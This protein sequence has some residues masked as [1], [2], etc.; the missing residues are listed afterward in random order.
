MK[1]VLKPLK[2]EQFEVEADPDKT[3]E[4]LKKLVAEARSE[5]PAD[6][7]KLIYQGK[8][9]ADQSKIE[10]YSI[11]D[12]G[13]VVVMVAKAK[14]AA[15][16]PAA[17]TTPAPAAPAAPAPGPTAAAGAAPEAPS[18]DAPM[19]QETAAAS[20]V[21]GGAA[22]ATIASLCDMGFEREQVQRCLQAAFN[23]PERAVEYLMSGIPEGLTGS[24]GGGGEAAEPAGGAPAAA[25]AG[26]PAP[27]GSPTSL[28]PGAAAGGG[29]GATPFPAMTG[30]G[31]A[32]A[33]AG[34]GS[35]SEAL[36]DELRRHP[37]FNQL[38]QMVAQNP[39]ML[40]Q[41]LPS[42]AQSNPQL[43]QAISE[44]PDGFMQLLQ[45]AAGAGAEGGGDPVETMLAAVGQGQAPGGMGGGGPAP[46]MPGGPTVVRLSEEENSAVARLCD[47]GFDRNAAAQAYLACDK[48]EELAANFLFESMETDEP[49]P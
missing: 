37:R 49:G 38:A 14:P 19:T 42:L 27:G 39:Q 9:L 47:L 16:P 11:K 8:I 30:A 48:N 18:T 22:E 45:S 12:G 31:A 36:F 15:S 43:M 7:Q 35:N 4:E 25:P 44:N 17:A 34:G 41:V 13:F 2:G 3:V 23:N 5:F 1:I 20:L 40:Q 24:P 29:G 6:Q 21:T 28:A 10:E 46:G 26:P 33:P 32:P